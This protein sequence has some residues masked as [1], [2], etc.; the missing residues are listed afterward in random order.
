MQL[1]LKTVVGN[2]RA[3]DPEIAETADHLLPF[4]S[5]LTQ[6]YGIESFRNTVKELYNAGFVI[7][8]REAIDLIPE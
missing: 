2:Y 5:P 8:Q 1:E 7:V 6:S 4:M 3:N